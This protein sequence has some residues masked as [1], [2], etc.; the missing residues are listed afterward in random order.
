MLS[1][2]ETTAVIRTVIKETHCIAVGVLFEKKIVIQVFEICIVSDSS[3][4]ML[5][6]YLVC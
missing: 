6:K 3:M 2:L 1:H 4:N 5:Y